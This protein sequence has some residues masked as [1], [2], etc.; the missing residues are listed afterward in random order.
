MTWMTRIWIGL[1]MGTVLVLG[2]LLGRLWSEEATQA[3]IVVKNVPSSEQ[4]GNKEGGQDTN[5]KRKYVASRNGSKYYPQGCDALERIHKE[6]RM[7]F[8]TEKRAKQSGREL[9]ELCK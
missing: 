5:D 8:A 3:D 6:N 9:S 7:Y 4:M 2:V 1:M